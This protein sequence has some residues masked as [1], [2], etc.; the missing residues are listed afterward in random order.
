MSYLKA[1]ARISTAL[2]K[3][4][5]CA[6]LCLLLLAAVAI[7]AAP[8]VS[9]VRFAAV[10]SDSM[11][12][13]MSRG[14]MVVVWPVEP[15]QIE[16]GDIILF[17]A[18]ADPSARIAHRV[19]QIAPGSNLAFLTKGDA[20][21][22][23]DRSPV[24]ADDVL[25]KVRF[26]LPLLGHVTRQMNEPLVFLLVLAVPGG[27]IIAGEV[28][29]IVGE[30]RRRKRPAASGWGTGR[31]PAA[32]VAGPVVHPTAGERALTF[33]LGGDP[34]GFLDSPE[35]A[36][37]QPWPDMPHLGSVSEYARQP[38]GLLLLA[39]VPGSLIVAGGVWSIL[40]ARKGRKS[41]GFAPE[42]RRESGTLR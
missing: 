25:G 3:G 41:N 1:A 4:L 30:L 18:P 27:F 31:G 16:V 7:V 29:N 5:A 20:N 42:A 19:V 35:S 12:P 15:S 13:A 14:D 40:R 37:D 6:I 32:V 38:H 24:P 2:V 8:R 22:A 11:R 36:Q 33:R 28:W 34:F 9:G 39:G 26:H 17:R 10:L 21:E 23:V